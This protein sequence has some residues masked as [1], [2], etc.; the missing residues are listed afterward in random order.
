MPSLR[1]K[2][3]ENIMRIIFKGTFWHLIS[4][5]E[6]VRAFEAF[7]NILLHLL[8]IVKKKVIYL[9]TL[10]NNKDVQ[11]GNVFKILAKTYFLLK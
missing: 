4:K 5:I 3:W 11:K 9:F 6:F 10:V 2:N 8:A 7:T 1:K